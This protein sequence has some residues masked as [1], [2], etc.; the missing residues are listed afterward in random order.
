MRKPFSTGVSHPPIDQQSTSPAIAERLISEGLVSLAE[1]AAMLPPVRGKKTSSSS[2]FRW[3]VHGKEGVKL[4]G[5]RLHGSGF[6]TS[7]P[8]LARF[9]SALTSAKQS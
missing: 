9:A 5:I 7:K 4:E 6:W 1:I 2:V 3:I 8:A